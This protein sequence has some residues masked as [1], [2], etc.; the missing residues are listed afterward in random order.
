MQK[1]SR[2]FFS[3][4]ANPEAGNEPEDQEDGVT[5]G[6]ISGHETIAIDQDPDEF[7]EPAPVDGETN[8][9]VPEKQSEDTMEG[10]ED[11][12]PK[13]FE[14]T[15]RIT[16]D[17]AT[18]QHPKRERDTALY[19]PGPRDRDRGST[20][21]VAW[22]AQILTSIGQPLFEVRDGRRSQDGTACPARWYHQL[23]VCRSFRSLCPGT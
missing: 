6:G 13:P 23:I 19:I 7:E 10:E 5:S 17:P 11:E 18:E 22:L 9:E 2:P 3:R 12:N 21:E 20:P 14:L 15:R 1:Q 16:F 8:H 4:G